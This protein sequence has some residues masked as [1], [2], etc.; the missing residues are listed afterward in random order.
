MGA[1]RPC[2]FPCLLVA[3]ACL[4]CGC[5]LRGAGLARGVVIV[6]LGE[7]ACLEARRTRHWFLGLGPAS[8]LLS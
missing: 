3:W 2:S 6:S 5:P 4:R 7:V 8:G 1:F